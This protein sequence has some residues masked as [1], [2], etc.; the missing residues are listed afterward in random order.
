MLRG[1]AVAAVA[2]VVLLAGF[3]MGYMSARLE[4]AERQVSAVAEAGETPAPTPVAYPTANPGRSFASLEAKVTSLLKYADAEGAVTLVELGS[5][6]PSSWS[7]NGDQQFTAA[8]TYKLP[9]LMLEAQNMTSGRWKTTDRLCFNDQDFEAG[10]YNDYK[11]GACF[12]RQDLERRAGKNSDNTAARILVRYAGGSSQLNSYAR[13]HGARNSTFYTPNTTTSNDLS[14]LW[15]D[16]F[17]DRAGG[18][19]AQR[20]LYPLLTNTS[21]EQGIPAG[22]PARSSEVVH[23]IGILATILND[24]ALVRTGPKGPYLLVILTDGVGA[25][26]AGWKLHADISRAVWQYEA[27]R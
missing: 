7:I 15:F 6:D 27:S 20:Y 19:A 12:T 21:Y 22:I 17:T 18:S 24:A 16:E 1:T 4:F 23:K 10:W 11:T 25:S 9:L 13:N 8:S 14:R 5:N 3:W 2:V 26:T